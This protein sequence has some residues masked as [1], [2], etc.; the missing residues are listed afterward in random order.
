MKNSPEMTNDEFRMTK[1]T[2]N[3]NGEKI[4]PKDLFELRISDFVRVSTFGFRTSFLVLGVFLAGCS[5][6][7]T[8][9]APR[10]ALSGGWSEPESGGATNRPLN[11]AHWWTTFD[12]PTLNSLIGRAV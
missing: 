10:S 8:Y 9:H 11:A 3:R 5:V 2:R 6:G 1:K 4:A 12:A 7:P